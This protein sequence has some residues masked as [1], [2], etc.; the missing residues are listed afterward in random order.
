MSRSTTTKQTK[1]LDDYSCSV[2]GPRW[3]VPGEES[4][5]Q[6]TVDET[7]QGKVM[8]DAKATEQLQRIL[9]WQEDLDH[10]L[11]DQEGVA[12]FLQFVKQDAGDDS[13]HFRRL[14]FY[15]ACI[16]LKRADRSEEDD[17]RQLIYAIYRQVFEYLWNKI[18]LDMSVVGC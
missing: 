8:A 15:F 12:L 11:D 14:Q 9:K 17:L 6:M 10:L 2:N 5:A 18:Q 16:G 13:A 4:R 3:P 1:D 7:S